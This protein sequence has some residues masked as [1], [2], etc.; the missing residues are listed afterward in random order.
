MSLK[1]EA[2]PLG[3]LALISTHAAPLHRNSW[4]VSVAK[5]VT[6]VQSAVAPVV[7]GVGLADPT[8]D[9][10]SLGCQPFIMTADLNTPKTCRWSVDEAVYELDFQLYDQYGDLIYWDNIFPTEFQMTLL[11]TEGEE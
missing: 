9:I 4:F 8:S 1:C 7:S 11:A 6:P 10:Y 5:Y 2:L 3:M